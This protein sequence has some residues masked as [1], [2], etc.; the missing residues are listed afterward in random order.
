MIGG[1]A[2]LIIEIKPGNTAVASAL[3]S[4]LYRNPELIPSVAMIMSFDLF[5]M[6]LL[7]RELNKARND[8]TNNSTTT[9]SPGFK[10][11][12]TH[13]VDTPE[14]LTSVTLPS[15]MLIT[16]ADPPVHKS[17]LRFQINEDVSNIHDWIHAPD[18]SL[19][20]VY[21]QYEQV[22]KTKE[23][24]DALKK[25]GDFCD[26]GVWNYAV[27]DPDD[28][29]TFEYLIR[30]GG[31]KVRIFSLRMYVVIIMLFYK[32]GLLIV[33][34]VVLFIILQH[35]VLQYRF[36]IDFQTRWICFWRFSKIFIL[37]IYIYNFSK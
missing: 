9:P 25:L 33:K 15:L 4:L 31:V 14:T 6:H 19:D 24:A 26:V 36:T 2:K 5:I 32:E 3:A 7:R 17:E 37:K 23:G 34:Y 13:G 21:L 28:Y 16:T 35:T 29:E 10:L 27:R 30:E 20:G 8:S 18:G 12:S 22:M 1:N 11:L